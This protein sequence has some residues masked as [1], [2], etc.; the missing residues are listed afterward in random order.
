MYL[1]RIKDGFEVM[2]DAELATVQ[3]GG[4]AYDIG[5]HIWNFLWYGLFPRLPNLEKINEEK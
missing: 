2:V 3:G 4:L 1:R 5:W